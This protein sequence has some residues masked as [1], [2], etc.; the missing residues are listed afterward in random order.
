VNCARL[1]QV[2]DGWLD[3]ELD[4]AT[5]AEIERHVRGCPACAVLKEGRVVL[6]QQLRG[7]LPRYRAPARLAHEI[8]AATAPRRDLGRLRAAAAALAIAVVSAAGGYWAGRPAPGGSVREQVV[9]SHVASLGASRRLVEIASADRHAVKP[10]FQG[11]VDFAPVVRDLS[12]EG[13][14]L[15]G[16]RLDH[17]AG[18][19]AT[20]IVYR[21]RQHVINL[22]VWRAAT[23][24]DEPL[25]VAPA[26]GF[27]L[28]T[29]SSAGLRFAAIAD[30]DAREMERFARLVRADA[31]AAQ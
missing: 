15:L 24:E 23:Q 11:K 27:S 28:A 22:Y 7:E 2:L 13:Y 29:W 10:W 5:G 6:G 8:H 14:V 1:R 16:A 19:Q 26:R 12:S 3:G 9:A 21:V 4:P 31:G 17:V 20:A 30:T 18:G 25:A